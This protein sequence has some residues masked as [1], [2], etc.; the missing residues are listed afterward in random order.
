MYANFDE[1]SLNA[2]CIEFE[3]YCLQSALALSML[4]NACSMLILLSYL[5]VMRACSLS[6]YAY[7]VLC[8]LRF[9]V[10]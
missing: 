4:M 8:L 10:V 9:Y 7:R 1:C 5:I 6:A 2:C 3:C